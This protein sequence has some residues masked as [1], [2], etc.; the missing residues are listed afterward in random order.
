M[1]AF[2]YVIPEAHTSCAYIF[3][4]FITIKAKEEPCKEI[5]GILDINAGFVKMTVFPFYA[6]CSFVRAGLRA[7]LIG[8]SCN[9]ERP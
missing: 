3:S 4:F 1:L 5:I 7:S 6:A 8:A 9:S 2:D